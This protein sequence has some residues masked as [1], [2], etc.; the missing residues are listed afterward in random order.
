MADDNPAI[1]QFQRDLASSL[2]GIGW[3]LAQAGKTDEAIGYFSE[4]E[5]IRQKLAEAS[6]ATPDDK[7]CLANCLTNTADVLRR[8]GRLD[9]ALAACERALAVREPLVEAHPDAPDFRAGLG[10]TYLRL[11]QVRCDMKNLAGAAAAWRRALAHYDGTKTL[12]GE[13]TFLLACCHAGLAGLAGRPGSGVSAAE[14]ADQAEKAMAVLRQAVAMGYRNP[15]SYRT[16]SA[17]DPL[18]NRPD[19]QLL[20]M[21]LVFPTKP[22][23]E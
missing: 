15:N 1:P 6:S 4:E 5:A 8:S 16:E 9:E 10:E 23:A 11:G 22:F 20:M 2:L 21:D 12:S 19:F 17:L 3:Q 18:R 13:S 7:D 14:G